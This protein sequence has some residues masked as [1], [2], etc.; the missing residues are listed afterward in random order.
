[1]SEAQDIRDDIERYLAENTALSPELRRFMESLLGATDSELVSF[2]K[3]IERK[4]ESDN[5]R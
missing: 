5:V 3:K 1:M 4:I 2:I